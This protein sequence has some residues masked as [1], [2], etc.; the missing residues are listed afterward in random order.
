MRTLASISLFAL[1]PL[2][3]ALHTNQSRENIGTFT[4][5]L[6]G[7]AVGA[8]LTGGYPG[9]IFGATV[10]AF[11]GNRVGKDFDPQPASASR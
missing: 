3:A 1:L 7:G 10:G 5:A 11:I 6:L 2:F 4:G 8:G 9:V